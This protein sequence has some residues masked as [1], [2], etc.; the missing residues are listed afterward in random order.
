M[1]PDRRS[2]PRLEVVGTL[3]ASLNVSNDVHIINIGPG[4][5]L[6]ESTL[7][8]LV[9]STREVTLTLNGE[10]VRFNARV[11]H[12]T[13][14]AGEG[15]ENQYHIGLEFLEPPDASVAALE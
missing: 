10:S 8:A 14:L 2:R 3:P 5:A 9:G 6:I 4:G 13:L 1:S 15:S 7:P 11:R 12:L